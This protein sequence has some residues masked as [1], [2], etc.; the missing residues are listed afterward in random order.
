MSNHAWFLYNNIIFVH[1]WTSPRS[2]FHHRLSIYLGVLPSKSSF[3]LC[4]SSPGLL[5]PVLGYLNYSAL[6]TECPCWTLLP[7]SPLYFFANLR[8]C[9]SVLLCSVYHFNLNWMKNNHP[10]ISIQ[11]KIDS[12]GQI[13]FHSCYSSK[14]QFGN[15]LKRWVILQRSLYCLLNKLAIS[16]SSPRCN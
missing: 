8:N 1:A 12:F 13:W 16:K 3:S 11:I 10:K 14:Q 7:A 2:D 4:C 6:T 5:C 15:I 9:W